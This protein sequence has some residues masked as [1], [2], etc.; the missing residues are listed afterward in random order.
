MGSVAILAI[1]PAPRFSVAVL[2]NEP[3]GVRRLEQLLRD[4]SDL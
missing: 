1:L 4:F 2:H 3:R